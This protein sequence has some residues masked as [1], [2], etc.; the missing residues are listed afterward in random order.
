MQ[1]SQGVT[2]IRV[3]LVSKGAGVPELQ[4]TLI[5]RKTLLG[6]PTPTGRCTQSKQK[7]SPSLLR[8]FTYQRALAQRTG[9]RFS[10][11]LKTKEPL[12]GNAS[13]GTPFLCT[14][15]WPHYS[16][17]RP[18][19]QELIH[20]SRAPILVTVAQGKPPG[21]PLWRPGAFYNCKP[22]RLYIY[23]CIP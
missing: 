3:A 17:R 8:K 23:I 11:N 10:T 12:P 19:K 21:L 5:T 18:P 13:K 4:V 20:S 14:P 1:T 9:F 22:T 6:R 15:P 7:H 16:S 2:L